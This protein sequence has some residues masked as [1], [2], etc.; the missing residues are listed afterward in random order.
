MRL[1]FH[2]LSLTLVKFVIKI[3]PKTCREKKSLKLDNFV[4]NDWISAV[5]PLYAC[6]PLLCCSWDSLV[7]SK[8]SIMKKSTQ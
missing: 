6:V 2:S 5:Y 4:S 1:Q 7:P 3:L 8:V